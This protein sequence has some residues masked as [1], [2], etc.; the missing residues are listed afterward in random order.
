MSVRE[1]I[2]LSS[3]S[4]MKT[5]PF[6]NLGTER[7]LASR[8][9]GE[10]QIKPQRIDSPV[11]TLSGGNRQKVVIARWLNTRAK[12]LIFD[13]PTAGIDVGARYEIYMMINRLAASGIGVMLISSDLPELLGICDRIA[14]MCQGRLTGVLAQSEA[15]QEKLMTLATTVHPGQSR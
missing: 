13:E 4:E 2:S 15:N 5:G 6:I 8:Y 1:N 3:L 7:A 14:V 10:L 12:L 9:V 11:D